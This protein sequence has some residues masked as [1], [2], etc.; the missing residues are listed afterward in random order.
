MNIGEVSQ[1]LAGLL[2]KASSMFLAANDDFA[3][4]L[5]M[6]QILKG[7]VLRSYDQGR[8]LVEF[9]G[10]EKVVDSS[11]PLKSGELVQ[12][13]VVGLGDKVELKRIPTTESSKDGMPSQFSQPGGFL[14]SR[15]DSMLMETMQKYQARFSAQDRAIIVSQL[16]KSER[17][18]L[19]LAS[20]LAI[21]KQGLPVSEKLLQ[22][23]TDLQTGKQKLSMLPTEQLAPTLG[24]AD[25][26]VGGHGGTLDQL[27]N[28]L[29]RMVQEQQDM[30]SQPPQGHALKYDDGRADTE[31]D[32]GTDLGQNDRFAVN[33]RLLNSQIGGSIQHRV[34]TLPV[35]LADRLLEINI[36]IYEQRQNQ[37]NQGNLNHRKIIFS[38]DLEMLGQLDIEMAMENRNLRLKV[39]SDSHQATRH[40]L[41]HGHSLDQELDSYGWILD[42]ISY[43]TQ[44]RD[45]MGQVVSSVIEHYMN[46]DSLSRL[47]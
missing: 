41:E 27:V 30:A 21:S 4:Q 24:Q 36:A 19:V 38:L 12:G 5:S 42:E 7:K 6:G 43:A 31:T 45:D 37:G 35:W 9:G 39:A 33:W 28:A 47:M 1:Q 40:L 2:S 18:Q 10:Q 25:A 26:N 8:Y 11:V 23:F 34:S 16:R 44:A 15:W 46:Q 22:W 29:R 3:S 13:R 14:A 20:A 17:P 32:G